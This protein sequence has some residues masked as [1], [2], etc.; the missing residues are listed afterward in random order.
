MAL[1]LGLLGPLSEPSGNCQKPPFSS[2]KSTSSKGSV[3]SGISSLGEGSAGSSDTME[4]HV[5]LESLSCF[6]PSRKT[7]NPCKA[8]E[9]F[10]PGKMPVFSYWEVWCLGFSMSP[11]GY[12]S[13]AKLYPHPGPLSCS[14]APGRGKHLEEP[15]S[16]PYWLC[17][18]GSDTSLCLRSGLLRIG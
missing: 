11:P 7:W 15:H 2:K 1:Q 6:D 13:K 4:G 14:G 8:K 3:L 9:S 10:G 5:C 17:K 16:F 18:R 12:P